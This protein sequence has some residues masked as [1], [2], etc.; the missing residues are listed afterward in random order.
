MKLATLKNGSRDGRLVVVSK[1]L[2]KATDAARIAPTLQAALDEYTA[3]D[4]A[5]R[6]RADGL[7]DAIG[8]SA[9][10]SFKLPARLERRNYKLHLAL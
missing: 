9:L 7:L 1:D 3:M 8:A 6:K 2:T 10:K 4:D 5:T